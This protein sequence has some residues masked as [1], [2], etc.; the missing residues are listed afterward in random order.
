MHFMQTALL[1]VTPVGCYDYTAASM[2]ITPCI[3][4]RA[5]IARWLQRLGQ[6]LRLLCLWL[7]EFTTHN[8]TRVFVQRCTACTS[9]PA[10]VVPF[11]LC[12]AA[13]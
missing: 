3:P 1:S 11:S 13:A 2:Y 10:S 6:R 5:N 12:S 4:F 7:L 9:H 8:V